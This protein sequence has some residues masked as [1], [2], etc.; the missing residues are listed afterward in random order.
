[1]TTMPK[2]I[3]RPP[4]QVPPNAAAIIKDMAAN[5]HSLVSI[6]SNL[7]TSKTLL[8]KWFE[9]EPALQE[10]FDVGRESERHA[11]H[12]MLFKEATEKGNTTAAM[13]LLKSRHGYREGAEVDQSGGVRI[14]ITLPGAMSVEEFSKGVT[15]ENGK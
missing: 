2:R 15:I 11:L 6:A 13:F 4:K 1:M 12:N 3:G 8:A 10:A 14:S 7:G 5:G 9:Q